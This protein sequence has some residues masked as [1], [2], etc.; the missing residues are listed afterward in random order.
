MK[1]LVV[2]DEPTIGEIIRQTLE[3]SGY[4]VTLNR[5]I[6]AV[7]AVLAET[8][9][10]VILDVMLPGQSGFEIT[11]ELRKRRSQIPIL[12]LTARDDI[13]DR[14]EGL[15]CGADDYLVKPFDLQEL[16]ARVRALI[17]RDRVNKSSVIQVSDLIVDTL[18][19]KVIRAGKEIRLTPREY[20]LLEALISRQGTVLTREVIQ[21]SVWMEED[22]Y[23]NTVDVYVMQLR[24]KIDQESQVKLI[25][26]VHGFGY[27]LDLPEEI[28]S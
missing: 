24:K 12:M 23:S 14:V 4:S 13:D 21:S 17:R 15:E 9:A 25:H 18:S 22:R 10:L 2:E 6:E 20:T 28:A 5:G 26:T 19:R 1:I 16:R 27:K 11:R 7:D 8:Y 3:E